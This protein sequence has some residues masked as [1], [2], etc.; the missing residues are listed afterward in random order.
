MHEHCM[1]DSVTGTVWELSYVLD[2]QFFHRKHSKA[3]ES[4]LGIISPVSLSE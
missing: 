3:S 2:A 4:S 1:N